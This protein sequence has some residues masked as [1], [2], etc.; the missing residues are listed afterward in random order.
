MDKVIY[1]KINGVR[2]PLGERARSIEEAK[3]K[4][5]AAYP[6]SGSMTTI[7]VN[8]DATTFTINIKTSGGRGRR[9]SKRRSRN[10]RRSSRSR[11]RSS[12]S[13]SSRRRSSRRSR[14]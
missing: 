4:Y 13:R 1:Y 7:D 10:S 2:K 11:S 8:E 14:K 6:A 9:G 12:R 3:Y 5:L